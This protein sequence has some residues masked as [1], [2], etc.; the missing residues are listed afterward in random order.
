MSTN[1]SIRFDIDVYKQ[2]DK[3]KRGWGWTCRYKGKGYGD[4][5][6]KNEDEAFFAGLGYISQRLLPEGQPQTP[7]Q[8]GGGPR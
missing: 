6:Y 4:I 7:R 8:R 2:P 3:K 1:K 5:G